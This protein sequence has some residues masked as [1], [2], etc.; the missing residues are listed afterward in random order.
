ME[1]GAFLLTLSIFLCA[2]RC[3]AQFEIEGRVVGVTDADKT[4]HKIRLAEIYAPESGQEFG[5][6][7]K[8][9]LSGKIFGKDVRIETVE[10]D[11]YGRLVGQVYLGDRWI[12]AEMVKEGW[13]WQYTRY[14]DSEE[15]AKL[16][17]EAR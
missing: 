17:H 13:A 1:P 16:Q 14:S 12:N 5:S 15:L 3:R 6:K 7:A 2:P 11:R 10:T 8:R 4:Q 9:V